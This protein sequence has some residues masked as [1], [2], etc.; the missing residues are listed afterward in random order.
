MNTVSRSDGKW[1]SMNSC[2]SSRVAVVGD[3][4]ARQQRAVQL[5]AERFQ[6]CALARAWRP[7][8]QCE[9]PLQA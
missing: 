7:Q 3:A 2:M 9:A 5:A 8:Q 1:T 6:Q 4:A